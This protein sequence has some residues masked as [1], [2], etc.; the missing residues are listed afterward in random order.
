MERNP[1]TI[2]PGLAPHRQAPWVAA[3]GLVVQPDQVIE[4]T[5]ESPTTP[6]SQVEVPAVDRAEAPERTFLATVAKYA[7]IAAVA[8]LAVAALSV[9]VVL[10]VKMYAV[11]TAMEMSMPTSM[12]TASTS[13]PSEVI[14]QRVGL[15]VWTQG[16]GAC[17]ALVLYFEG[18]QLRVLARRFIRAVRKH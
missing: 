2:R 18:E 7:Q 6:E 8:T 11:L 13:G 17:L 12:A 1:A 10:A 14:P 5:A 9:L 3:P 4:P 15:L 16:L